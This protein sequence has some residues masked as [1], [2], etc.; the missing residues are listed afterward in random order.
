M[1]RPFG[2]QGDLVG[3][4]LIIA[5]GIAEFTQQSTTKEEGNKLLLVILLGHGRHL[6]S[7]LMGGRRRW[8]ALCLCCTSA[9]A[10]E[11][12]NATTGV[13][14]QGQ[15]PGPPPTCFFL[16]SRPGHVAMRNSVRNNTPYEAQQ[17]KRAINDDMIE[18]Y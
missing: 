11:R 7:A 16:A 3:Q 15:D 14:G 17:S 2:S 5:K 18:F 1:G 13:P 8:R 4:I 10:L 6:K 9:E 12:T